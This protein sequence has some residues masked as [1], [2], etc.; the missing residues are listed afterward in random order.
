M[1]IRLIPV[2]SRRDLRRFIYLAEALHRDHPMWMPPLYSDEWAYFDP[3]RN[4]AFSYCDTTQVLAE[5]DGRLVGRVMGII[6]HRH[7]AYAGQRTA[8][9]SLLETTQDPEVLRALLG[10]VEGWAR[11]RGMTKVIGPF[12]FN[13]QD[14]EG[15][16]IEGFEHHPTIVTYYNFPWLIPMLEAEGYQKEVDY[17]V[18]RVPAPR[19]VPPLMAA[20]AERLEKRGFR[21]FRFRNRREARSYILP[22]LRLMN[23]SYDGIYGYTPLDDAEMADLAEKYLVFLDLRFVTVVEKDGE[24]VSFMIGVPDLWEGLVRSR[25]RLWPLG[26]YHLLRV[27]KRKRFRQ[28]DLLLAG[29]KE[30]YRGKGLDM[31]MGREMTKALIAAGVDVIDSHHELETNALVRAEMERQG[32]E[33]YKRYRVFQKGL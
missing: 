25:G 2:Q 14:P 16:Q 10:H 20:V 21:V 27:M 24:L 29:V 12:G 28:L 19:E 13:D 1:A 7:N 26:W 11:E 22:V 9:F 8:R 23:V 18:Y 30:G 17:V 32:G 31:L 3:R 5:Q 15:F 4:R 33:V 6:N